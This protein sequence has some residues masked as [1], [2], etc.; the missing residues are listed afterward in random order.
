VTPAL[1]PR[2]TML[3]IICLVIIAAVTLAV[4]LENAPIAQPKV[5]SVSVQIDNHLTSTYA[6]SCGARHKHGTACARF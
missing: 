3:I 2:T 5:V 6:C 4:R 1:Y